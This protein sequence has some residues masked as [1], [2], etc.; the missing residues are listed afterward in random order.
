MKTVTFIKAL[1]VEEDKRTTTTYPEGWAGEV[2][3]EIAELAAKEGC[4]EAKPKPKA[5]GK[6]EDA[7][8][9]ETPPA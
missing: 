9:A 6:A 5:K 7:A 3:D 1:T 4:I 8:D 2:S